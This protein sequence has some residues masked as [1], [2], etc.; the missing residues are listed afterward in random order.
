M[1]IRKSVQEGS[2]VISQSNGPVPRTFAIIIL[3]VIN[4]A[5]EYDEFQNVYLFYT[6]L[7]FSSSPIFSLSLLLSFSTPS[8]ALSQFLAL[9]R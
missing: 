7:F 2:I 9:T 5:R 8:P 1:L 6:V 4:N 3:Q